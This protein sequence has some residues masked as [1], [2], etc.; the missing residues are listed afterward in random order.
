MQ[1]NID[2]TKKKEQL[3]RKHPEVMINGQI[4]TYHN[5]SLLSI[6]NLGGSHNLTV[7]IDNQNR[8]KQKID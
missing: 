5:S 3:T 7:P 4:K 1:N 2:E 8:S 6:R